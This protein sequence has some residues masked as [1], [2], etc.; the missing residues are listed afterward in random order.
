MSPDLAG[1]TQLRPARPRPALWYSATST[2][3]S[4]APSRAASTSALFVEE[5]VATMSSAA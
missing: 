4:G 2:V 5:T 3:R 1:A